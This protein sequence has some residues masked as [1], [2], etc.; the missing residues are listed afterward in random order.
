MSMRKNTVQR[1][2][3]ITLVMAVT[4][5]GFIAR[6]SNDFVSWSSPADKKFFRKISTEAGVVIMGRNTFETFKEPLKGRLNVV[7]SSKITKSE[8][9]N[10]LFYSG[11]PGGLLKLLEEKGFKRAVLAGGSYTNYTFLKEKLIDSIVL[12]ISPLM[13]GHGLSLFNGPFD[14]ELKI[15]DFGKLDDET[16][17]VKY[18]FKNEDK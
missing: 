2:I 5:D 16:L 9:E 15:D 17:I 13:F 3:K 8:H 11:S 4:A 10:T 12:T 18:S 7:M 1:Q 6:D 14:A